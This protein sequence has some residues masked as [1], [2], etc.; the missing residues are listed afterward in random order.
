MNDNDLMRNSDSQNTYHATSNLNTAI[1]NPQV[2][3]NSAMG[4]NLQNGDSNYNVNQDLVN[5]VANFNNGYDINQNQFSS[6]F[7][8]NQYDTSQNFNVVNDEVGTSQYGNVGSHSQ[9]IPNTNDTIGNDVSLYNNEDFSN[10][11]HLDNVKYE[12]TMVEKKKPDSG[13]KLSKEFKIMMVI[14]FI[15]ILFVL[16]MP[17]VYDFFKELELVITSG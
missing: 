3:I 15:L 16:V 13:F 1:E 6:N 9:F 7:N 2:N 10:N 12:P 11:E 8:T 14:V 17:Y 5:N 4:V